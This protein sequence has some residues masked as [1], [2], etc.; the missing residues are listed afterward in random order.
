[1]ILSPM[2]FSV[3][4]TMLEYCYADQN[5]EI[6][7]YFYL[8]N[9]TSQKKTQKMSLSMGISDEIEVA[10]NVFDETTILKIKATISLPFRS[11]L[12]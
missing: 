3:K 4:T 6:R 11:S 1:M 5:G 12:T 10:T 9:S 2:Y 7:L 8:E